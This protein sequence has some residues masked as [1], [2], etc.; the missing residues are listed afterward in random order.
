ML[1]AVPMIVHNFHNKV[2]HGLHRRSLGRA[3]CL[4]QPT[5]REI[6]HPGLSLS[7]ALLAAYRSRHETAVRQID[8]AHEHRAPG[9]EGKIAKV[10]AVIEGSDG[11]IDR[12]RDDT[13][14]ADLLRG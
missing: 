10:P 3:K 9:I 12:M 13:E 8:H 1:S 2:S 4:T 7:L 11:V 14:A 6:P 5:G